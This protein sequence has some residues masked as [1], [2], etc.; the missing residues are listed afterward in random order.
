MV[1]RVRY[2]SAHG[3]TSV[4]FMQHLVTSLKFNWSTKT[5]YHVIR[6]NMILLDPQQ[7]RGAAVVQCSAAY[8]Q[9]EASFSQLR[10]VYVT[11]SRLMKGSTVCERPEIR[12]LT[13]SGGMVAMILISWG[14]YAFT[15]D[16]H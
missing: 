12:G 8:P 2:D 7:C 4:A 6:E 14:R 13:W 15:R 11:S 1:S 9:Q 3:N 5:P 10:P 16:R